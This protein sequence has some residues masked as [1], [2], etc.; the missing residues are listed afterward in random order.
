M[1]GQYCDECLSV[2]LICLAEDRAQWYVDVDAV[3]EFGASTKGVQ[4]HLEFVFG[5]AV[6]FTDLISYMVLG[7][8]S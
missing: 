1:L 2:D 6:H 5:Q 3:K 7:Y 8:S 4:R